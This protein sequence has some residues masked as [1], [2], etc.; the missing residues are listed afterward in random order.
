MDPVFSAAEENELLR[1]E[2]AMAGAGD[3]GAQTGI[4][5]RRFL[6]R[7]AVAAASASA[8]ALGAGRDARANNPNYLPSLY[9]GE[10]LREF[11]A[12]QS[13]ENAHVTF[14]TQAL[15]SYARPIPSFVNLAQPTLL[16]FAQT[17]RALENTGVGAYL[18]AAP[19]IYSRTYLGAAGSILTIE[20]RHA[21]YLNVL[22]NELMTTNVENQAQSFETPLTQ[23]QVV[24]LAGPFITSLNGGPPLS[25][26]T[27]PS[28]SNDYAILNFALALE[29]LEAAFYNVNVPLFS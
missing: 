16:A 4:A 14:L 6:R 11:Q 1:L 25:F 5:R 29:Y 22:L 28:A 21:G 13:H 19:I 7:G 18:G 24:D 26:S 20:A 15:G 27:T 2:R 23:S 9:A 3:S 17:A 8:I 10:N 12:I